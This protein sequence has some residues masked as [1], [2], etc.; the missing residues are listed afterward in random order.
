MQI[1]I[2]NKQYDI[3]FIFTTLY[4]AWECDSE[5]L[6]VQDEKK[7]KYVVLTSHGSP[8]IANRDD[9]EDLIGSYYDVIVQTEKAIRILKGE[10]KNA[11]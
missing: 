6:I 5:G 2:E 1:T 3:L 8:Y 4:K 7:Q 10:I 11:I 9:L